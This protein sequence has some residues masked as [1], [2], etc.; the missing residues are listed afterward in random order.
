MYIHILST[1]VFIY[2]YINIFSTVIAP[3]IQKSHPFEIQQVPLVPWPAGTAT[4][5][6][7]MR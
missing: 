3:D 1:H 7:N 2:I 6:G 4:A 5:A